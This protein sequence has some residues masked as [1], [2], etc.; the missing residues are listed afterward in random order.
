[1]ENDLVFYLKLA[2]APF[3]VIFFCLNVYLVWYFGKMA[4]FYINALEI[5]TGPK[6]KILTGV[7]IFTAIYVL[8]SIFGDFIV[9]QFLSYYILYIHKG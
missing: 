4:K 8:F 9:C 1:M 7:A 6:I 5:I 3:C 2:A